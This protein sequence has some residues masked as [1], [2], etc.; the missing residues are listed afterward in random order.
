[1]GKERD[2]PPLS[3]LTFTSKKGQ[4][5]AFEGKE[6][7]ITSIALPQG[8]GAREKPKYFELETFFDGQSVGSIPIERYPKQNNKVTL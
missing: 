8:K 7:K 1:M 6:W 3:A 2:L 4:R 5:F